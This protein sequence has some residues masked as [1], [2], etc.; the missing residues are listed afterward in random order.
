MA[1]V[2][3]VGLWKFEVTLDELEHIG[4][5]LLPIGDRSVRA[6]IKA[7]FVEMLEADDAML[8]DVLYPLF[9]MMTPQKFEANLPGIRARLKRQY[10]DG[11]GFIAQVSSARIATAF[12][13]LRSLPV[14]K[15]WKVSKLRRLIHLDLLLDYWV[16]D[17]NVP[18]ET[19]REFA[20]S[21]DAFLDEVSEMPTA[22]GL[23]ALMEG[24]RE[25][26]SCVLRIR[27]FLKHFR[28][29]ATAL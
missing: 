11:H 8:E 7:L 18:A 2:A 28:A 10:L 14:W 15:T 1:S 27:T 25:A 6:G 26:H 21:L 17:E 9:R 29:H 13:K 5:H 19:G 16:R 4:K 24:L 23:P 20:R 22:K 12:D 3:L